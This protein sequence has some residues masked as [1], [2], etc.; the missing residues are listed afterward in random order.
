M[1]ISVDQAIDNCL[2][3]EAISRAAVRRNDTNIPDSLGDKLF[4][5]S[6][7]LSWASRHPDTAPATPDL[8]NDARLLLS[9]S[10]K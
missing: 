10:E 5:M 6:L 7:K 1:T 4:R 9:M 2:L 3:K 8:L